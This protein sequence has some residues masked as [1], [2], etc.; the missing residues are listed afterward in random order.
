MEHP[1]RSTYHD[2]EISLVDLAKILIY[3]RWWFLGA[4]L[5]VVLASLSWVLLKNTE[6]QDG[7]IKYQYTTQLAVGYKTPTELIEPLLSIEEQLNGAIIPTVKQGSDEFSS[8]NVDLKYNDG[9]NIIS[10]VTQAS[11]GQNRSVTD[12]HQALIEP[13]V[14]RHDR[15]LKNLNQQPS[16]FFQDGSQT[17][18]LVPSERVSLAVKT[19]QTTLPQGPN[20]KLI[21]VLGIVLGGIV[22]VIVAFFTEFAAKVRE[23]IKQEVV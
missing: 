7:T 12:F 17:Q 18:Q 14:E 1:P 10:L 21:I 8:L 11:E 16:S 13:I 4:F 20:A 6:I 9:S 3:R 19:P 22:G 23:S 2:D 15:L 5:I